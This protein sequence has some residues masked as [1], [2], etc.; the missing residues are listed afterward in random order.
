MNAH[1]L[2]ILELDRALDVVAGR[3]SS[4]L[5]AE[6]IRELS[7]TTDVAWLKDELRRVTAT[8]A[9]LGGE[10]GWRP[11]PIPDIRGALGRLRVEG[12]SWNGQ[13]LLG[14][15]RLL[16]SSRQTVDALSDPRHP[17]VVVAILGPMVSRLFQ[18]RELERAIDDVVND[19]ASVRDDASPTLRRVR[20]ELRGAHGQ[21]IKLLERIMG[22][23]EP[24]QAVPDMSVTLRNGRYVIPVRAQARA[25]VGGIVH[26][27]SGTGATL[28][29]E[30]PAAVEFGNRIRE[31]EAEEQR[32]VER[33]LAELTQRLRPYRESL[34]STL[35][36]LVELDS[37]YGRARFGHEFGCG[38]SELCRPHEGFDIRRGRHPLLLAQGG[39]VVPFDLEMLPDER[40]LL[41]S[42]PNTGGKTVLIKA[43]GLLSALTQCGIPVPVDDGS[44]IPVFDGFFADVGDEQSL[45]ASLSTFS[46]HL[47]NL[48]EIL[49]AATSASLVLVDELGSGTDPLEGAALG[50]AILEELTRRRTT[51]I[52]TTHLGALKELATEVSGVV[53]ASLQFDAVALAPTYRL[54]KGVPGRSYGL[55]IARR[56][57]FPER[58][59]AR[60]EERVPRVERDV[61]ALLAELEKRDA[62]LAGKEQDVA[63]READVERRTTRLGERERA[64]RQREREAERQG[65]QEARQYALQ[66]RQEIERTIRSLRT[67]GAESIDEAARQA[68][69]SA[70][71]LVG[72]Q[73]EQLERLEREQLNVARR[74]A[75]AARDA[76]GAGAM[77]PP[78]VG[79]HVAISTLG[80]RAGRVLELRDGTAA[81]LVGSVRMQLPV[82]VLTRTAAP[83]VERVVLRGDAPE[84]VIASELDLRGM[85][86]HE[87]DTLLMQALDAAVR[88][89]LKSL[90][91]IHGKGTGALRS[92]VDEMLRKDTR[93]R[94]HRLGAWNEGGTGVTV[95]DLT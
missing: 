90:R 57:A 95:V 89:D 81:V 39:Q 91:I 60:A 62:A 56:L 94:A 31:L 49:E 1:A 37:L 8:R 13:E 78:A 7:P 64:V 24:H 61:E 33:I 59:L 20:R 29:V 12:A 77:A 86:Y 5:G 21:L 51:T 93:V 17:A 40:T 4:A 34:A 67:A 23:L 66:A 69:R 9:I 14:A 54:I 75:S 18:S 45:Q 55:G 92:R 88:A 30:P 47:K 68:R 72:R 65:R 32:E 22:R 3:A 58:V 26:D 28:F 79:D 10:E 84:E 85:R 80:G 27:S 16:H 76:A 19:D 36:V 53:N 83:A 71:E 82:S 50:G 70:E 42:G 74:T 87:V 73:N 46:A 11:E 2:G 48:S 41:V 25:E 6:R 43:I 63:T 38:A 52:A 35:D 44:R 15:S